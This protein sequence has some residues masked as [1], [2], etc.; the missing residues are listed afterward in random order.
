[1]LRGI[2]LASKI[3]HLPPRDHRLPADILACGYSRRLLAPMAVSNGLLPV[4]VQHWFEVFTTVLPTPTAPFPTFVV[5]GRYPHRFSASV[6]CYVRV[7]RCLHCPRK[8]WHGKLGKFDRNQLVSVTRAPPIRTGN[9]SLP[10]LNPGQ[11]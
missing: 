3:R 5:D 11:W 9:L 2:L 1:M 10:R 7:C 4:P 8:L 6:Q